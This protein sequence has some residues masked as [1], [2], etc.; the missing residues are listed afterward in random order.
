MRP[1]LLI[2]VSLSLLIPLFRTSTATAAEEKPTPATT[3]VDVPSPAGPRALGASLT[4]AADGTI[5]LTWVEAAAENLAAA[6]AKKKSGAHHH[7]PAPASS[8]GAPAT[9][10]N[11]LRFATFAPIRALPP[12]APLSL[13]PSPCPS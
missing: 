4:T 10:P 5:W 2:S 3:F 1:A 6:A 8:A 11:T 13:S 9:P 7:A 12:C